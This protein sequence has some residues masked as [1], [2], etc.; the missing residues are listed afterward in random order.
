MDAYNRFV[1][2]A[3]INNKLRGITIHQ[4]FTTYCNNPQFKEYLNKQEEERQYPQFIETGVS[5]YTS[6][7]VRSLSC[8]T[9]IFQIDEHPN[10]AIELITNLFHITEG[11]KKQVDEP[12]G[13]SMVPM[14]IDMLVL[15]KKYKET[16][17]SG[18]DDEF[19]DSDDDDE[20]EE[21]EDDDEGH[22]VQEEG[23]TGNHKVD[24]GDLKT[25]FQSRSIK[26]QFVKR[27]RFLKDLKK[28]KQFVNR[29]QCRRTVL[30]VDGRNHVPEGDQNNDNQMDQGIYMVQPPEPYGSFERVE[31]LCTPS[32]HHN[33]TVWWCIKCLYVSSSFICICIQSTSEMDAP[34][35]GWS[36]VL[37]GEGPSRWT[38]ARVFIPCDANTGNPLLHVLW[39]TMSSIFP[40]RYFQC[41]SG[42]VC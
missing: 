20:D 10:S 3:W 40:E 17:I 21:I 32:L 5:C 31:N 13:E 8:T 15:H 12:F 27:R 35:S 4:F 19:S 16:K 36:F 37:W 30:I 2:T 18:D 11:I 39:C 41:H 6:R 42:A 22:E 25:L 38:D 24:F 7:L 9:P 33:S 14:Q 29:Q 26:Y 23:L 1:L 28:L 34:W